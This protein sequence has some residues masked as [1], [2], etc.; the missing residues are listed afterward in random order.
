M[1]GRKRRVEEELRELS[2]QAIGLFIDEISY[3]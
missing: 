2:F 1:Y 3:K